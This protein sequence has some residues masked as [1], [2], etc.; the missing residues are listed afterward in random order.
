M[1]IELKKIPE[2][3]IENILKTIVVKSYRKKTMRFVIIKIQKLN[4]SRMTCPHL[5]ISLYIFSCIS[6]VMLYAYLVYDAFLMSIAFVLS[7]ICYHLIS[8]F[9]CVCANLNYDLK[10]LF[11]F[12]FFTQVIYK[13]S[14]S[15]MELCCT[16][17]FIKCKKIEFSNEMSSLN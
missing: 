9:S 13:S 15:I 3:S 11:W 10:R 1:K 14:I 8:N 12:L 17:H 6:N 5:F 2:T 7:I 16:E 4:N